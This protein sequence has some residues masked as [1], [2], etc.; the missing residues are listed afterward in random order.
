MSIS[1]WLNMIL[2]VGFVTGFF[3][4]CIY[5]VLKEPEAPQHLHSQ[6]DIDTHD[7]E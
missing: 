2:S 7:Q 6:T 4:W 3:L 5:R 1:G